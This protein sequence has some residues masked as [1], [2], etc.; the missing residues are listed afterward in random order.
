M[1]QQDG[2]PRAFDG[3]FGPGSKLP[4][5]WSPIHKEPASACAGSTATRVCLGT[6]RAQ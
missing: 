4:Q 5:V 1:G 2:V 3:S 6:T